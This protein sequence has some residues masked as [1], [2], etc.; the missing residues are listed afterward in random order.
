[1]VKKLKKNNS[2][3]KKKRYMLGVSLSLCLIMTGF[4]IKGEIKQHLA[5]KSCSIE[6]TNENAGYTAN[7][8]NLDVDKKC[9]E[10]ALTKANFQ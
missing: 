10:N 4:G 6:T 5:E 8:K 3:E 2:N 1:M 7:N 9:L